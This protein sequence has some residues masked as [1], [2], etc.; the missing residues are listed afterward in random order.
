MKVKLYISIIIVLIICIMF[1]KK[2]VKENYNKSQEGPW[3]N[4]GTGKPWYN[5]PYI[6]N[7]IEY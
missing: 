1:L 7:N 3:G 2:N 6:L 5:Y 4:I